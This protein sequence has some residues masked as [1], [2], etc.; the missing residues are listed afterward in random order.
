MGIQKIIQKISKLVTN[1]N[2]IE[3]ETAPNIDSVVKPI[4]N[5]TSRLNCV[6]PIPEPEPEIIPTPE[7]ESKIKEIDILAYSFYAYDYRQIYMSHD[8]TPAS[9][10]EIMTHYYYNKSNS[11][12]QHDSIDD[13]YDQA[14]QILRKQKLE[15]LED[16]VE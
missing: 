14:N 15:K 1:S 9:Q 11:N 13:Y 2:N 5:L 10:L 12:H 8:R 16:N 4:F 3:V 6:V 7:S